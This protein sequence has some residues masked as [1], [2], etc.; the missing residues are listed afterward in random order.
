MKLLSCSILLLLT[1]PISLSK[2]H[3][4]HFNIHNPLTLPDKSQ[5]SM[6]TQRIGYSDITINY[7]SPGAKGREVWGALVPYGKVW[8]AGANENTVFTITDDVKI[9]GLELAAGSYGLHL[10]P[11]KDQ[12]TF[13]FSKNHTS[14]GSF[15]YDDKEDVLRIVVPVEDAPESRDWMSFDFHKRERG[16][17]SIVLTWANKRAKFDL[18]LDID[19]IAL[20]NIRKQLRSDA[21][22]EWFSWNQAA[23]YCA[24]YEI[25][26]KEAL[27]WVEHSIEMQENFS[28]LDVKAKLLRQLGDEEGAEKTIARAIEVGNAIYLERYGRRFLNQKDFK[29]AEI[30]FQQALKKDSKFWRAHF[31]RGKALIGM[32]KKNEA[33]EAFETALNYAPEANRGT[34][35]D[36]ILL[37]KNDI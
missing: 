24:Q 21:Y 29:N 19:S 1:V 27:Q 23:D 32:N 5:E 22:W 30:I 31:N 18:S 4:Q 6:I 12:W 15:F 8:R 11:E 13:I 25:N 36:S 7:H 17:L 14:W 20:D 37:L 3:A 16:K 10:L 34:I 28:N 35:N 9:E 2:V 33:L 26:T